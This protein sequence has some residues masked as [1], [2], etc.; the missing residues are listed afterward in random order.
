MHDVLTVLLTAGASALAAWWGGK[1]GVRRE[2]EKLAQARAFDRRLEWYERALKILLEYRDRT[3]KF[4][5]ATWRGHPDE[6]RFKK[7]E[8]LNFLC[9]KPMMY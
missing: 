3:V 5:D 6:P 9:D 7:R 4:C 8:Y 2:G 1:L